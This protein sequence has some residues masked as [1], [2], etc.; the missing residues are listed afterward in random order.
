MR[1]LSLGAGV[2]SSTLALLA[3]HG[4][5]EKPDC[6]IFADT[7]WEPDSVYKCLEWVKDN[8]SFPVYVVSAGN[9][10]EDLQANLSGS[11][12]RFPSMPFFT[13]NGGIGRRQCTNDYKIQPVQK[14]AR[15]LLGYAPRKRIPENSVQMMIGISLDEI[16]RMKPSRI[17]WVENVYPLIDQRMSRADCLIWMER[18]GYPEPPKSSCIGCPFH[19]NKAWMDIKRTDPESWKSAVAIDAELRADGLRGKMANEEY[20]HQS[21]KP[22]GEASLGDEQTIDMFNNECEGMCG[23]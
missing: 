7:G 6:A 13:S 14:K 15:E 11:G 17:K 21:L 2:Q 23:V 16:Q 3:E 12:K 10:K 19:S 18:Q 9:I 5:T 8:V 20:M 4:E 22:L 1:I